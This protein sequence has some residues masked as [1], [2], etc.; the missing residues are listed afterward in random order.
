M[1]SKL[2]HKLLQHSR[3]FMGGFSPSGFL[4]FCT[5]WKPPTASFPNVVIFFGAQSLNRYS[6]ISG[7]FSGLKSAALRC[8]RLVTV[9]H[10]RKNLICLCA[11]R[12]CSCCQPWKMTW[13]FL[14]FTLRETLQYRAVPLRCERGDTSTGSSPS[15]RRINRKLKTSKTA[16]HLKSTPE[17]AAG[18]LRV[19]RPFNLASRHVKFAVVGHH[20]LK[21]VLIMPGMREVVAARGRAA[22][23][24][25][26]SD[27][28][29]ISF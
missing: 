26:G 7:L 3:Y 14:A 10:R 4:Y 16:S 1:I 19:K 25:Q 21:G 20:P 11:L 22:Q 6:H 8:A 23:G 15:P 13:S 12:L 18:L 2:S 28:A 17:V 24:L 5:F 27:C 9:A 29:Q